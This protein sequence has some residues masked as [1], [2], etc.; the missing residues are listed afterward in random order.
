AGA[1]DFAVKPFMPRE[2]LARLRVAMWRHAPL[3]HEPSIA[4]VE[5][6]HF[7]PRAFA[8]SQSI[9]PGS[10]EDRLISL[11]RSREC[12]LVMTAEIIASVWG[13]EKR[14]TDRNLRVL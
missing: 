8:V 14:R 10:M 2:L 3:D 6:V 11:L 13:T 12:E 9:R 4:R 7:A 5:P 1:D